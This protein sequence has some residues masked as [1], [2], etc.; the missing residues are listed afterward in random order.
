[1]SPRALL[2]VLDSVGLGHAPDAAAYGD[3]GADTLGH[4]IDFD[5]SLPARLPNLWSLGL[6]NIL[7]R[8]PVPVPAASFGRMR[9]V[10]RG[11]DSTTGHWELAG[12]VL[13]EPFGLFERF[14]PEL[15]RA[16][17]AEAGVS[18]IG[19]C[20]AS[21]TQII[22]DLG[23]EHVRTGRPILYTSADSVLQIAA[24][25]DVIPVQRLYEI[26]RIARRHAD[27]FRIG[28]V[29][30]RPFVGAPGAFTR[31][32]RRHDFSMK[33]PRT[34]LNA[35]AERGL[36]V[37]SIG[38]VF[39]LFA[40]EGITESHPTDSNADGMRQTAKVWA[41]TDA[42]L[43]FTNLVDF[44]TVYG[45]RRDPAGYANAL[46]EFDR[47]LAGFLPACR[48][49]DLLILTA[50]HGNDPTYRGTDHTRERVPLL[51]RHAGGSVDLADRATFADVAATLAEFLGIEDGW[52]AAGTSFLDEI[53]TG[54][55]RSNDEVPAHPTRRAPARG[56]HDRR[57]V[58]WREPESP[59]RATGRGDGRARRA[60]AD[61]GG[62][63]QPGGSNPAD[64]PPAGRAPRAAGPGPRD[65][66]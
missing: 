35:I 28:R 18:F 65:P 62:L 38:K 37:K 32:A 42:G 25:E 43:V 61:P 10:S 64:R 66:Q 13:R 60:P 6:G 53:A 3:E 56:R 34:V 22:D 41:T 17:E 45:H 48:D 16:I 8:D 7:G 11:K 55:A 26:C 58:A 2:I 23:P 57:A 49:D 27:P 40:G 59:G 15:V 51:V 39:D 14:P 30:A 1:V 19:N 9:E 5:P 46:V 33:P 31:T 4:L 63:Q 52:P 50:D 20:P 36:P 54:G 44:D 21:G 24:H 29:I 47:W 12:V